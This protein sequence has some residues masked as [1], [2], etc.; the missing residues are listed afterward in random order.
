MAL[1]IQIANFNFHQYL[2]RANSSNLM[3]AKLS[4]YTVYYTHYTKSL[5]EAL[6]LVEHSRFTQCIG[7]AEEFG[8]G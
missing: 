4:R 3:L 2:L 1:R 5:P 8:L 7:P 6:S